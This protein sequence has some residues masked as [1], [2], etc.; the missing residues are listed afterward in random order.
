MD[1]SRTCQ[2]C[3]KRPATR[4]YHDGNELMRLCGICLRSWKKIGRQWAKL[5]EQLAQVIE[6]DAWAEEDDLL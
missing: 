1:K 2:Q 4:E 3:R 5:N 6:P